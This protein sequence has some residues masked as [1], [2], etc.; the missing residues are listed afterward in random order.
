MTYHH[1]NTLTKALIRAEWERGSAA[2]NIATVFGIHR[3]TVYRILKKDKTP[4]QPDLRSKKPT[5]GRRRLLSTRDESRLIRYVVRNPFD[6][7]TKVTT[8]LFGSRNISRMTVTRALERHGL[9]PYKSR[10]KPYISPKNKKARLDFAIEHKDWT[11][12]Q[13]KNVL[14]TDES[15]F[16][17]GKPYTRHRVIRRVGEALLPQHLR[18]SFGS[19]YKS[20]MVWGG[21]YGGGRT[22]LYF[23]EPPRGVKGTF[24]S[25]DY[26][27]VLNTYMIPLMKELNRNGRTMIFQQDN[28]TIHKA[29][30]VITHLL[31]QEFE[32]LVWPAQSPGLNLI[33][34]IWARMKLVIDKKFPGTRPVSDMKRVIQQVWDE[35]DAEWLEPYFEGMPGRIKAV[36]DA[37]GGP[38]RY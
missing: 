25:A 38:T 35:I 24:N 2:P 18:P 5:C 10:T 11:A 19:G 4:P 7:I 22:D 9:K 14:F 21:I 29:K 6:P 34:H 12:E 13:W 15:S 27:Q 37:K 16:Q 20:V 17:I 3:S 30:K 8:L 23:Y 33:E 31:S 32:T 26:I 36:I 1:V 28:A